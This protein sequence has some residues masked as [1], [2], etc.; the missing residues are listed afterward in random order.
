MTQK[1][2]T[3]AQ[4]TRAQDFLDLLGLARTLWRGKF[5]ITAMVL[6]CALVGVL[7]SFVIATPMYR[8][9]AVVVLNS[10]EE[11]VLDIESVVGGL[12]AD[13]AVMN[14]EV[15]VISSR[16]L[17]AEVVQTLDL[18][19]DPEFN[20][21]LRPQTLRQKSEAWV[22]AMIADVTGQVPSAPTIS[23]ERAQARVLRGTVNALEQAL[24]VR[25]VPQ[26]LVFEIT[27]ETTDPLK[28]ALISDTLAERYIENQLAVKYEATKQASGWLADRVA[29]LQ[30][31]LE[32]AEAKVKR[33]RAETDLVSAEALEAGERQLKDLRDR[34][35]STRATRDEA[36]ARL[37]LMQGA[38]DRRAQA[39]AAGDAQLRQILTRMSQEGMAEAFDLRFEQLIQRVRLE[40]RRFDTQLAALE[41]SMMQ[42]TADVE[43]Q[44][45]ELITLQQLSREAEASRLLYEYFL[46]RL[47]ETSAQQGLQQADSRILTP[48]EEPGGPATPRKALILGL[49]VAFGVLLGSALVLLREITS[50]TYRA[51]DTLESATGYAVMGQVPLIP[52][53]R[54]S[55]TLQYL[56]KKPTSGAAEAIRNLRTTVLM[57]DVRQ[58]PKVIMVSSSLPGEGKTT[59]SL[60][61]AQ[62]LAAMG[63]KVLL[64]EGDIRRRVVMKYL[65]SAARNR[66]GTMI[67][68]LRGDQPLAELVRPSGALGADVLLGGDG[69]MNAA[70]LFSSQGFAQMIETARAQYDHVVI[71]TPPVLVVPDARVISQF[72]DSILL[73][74]KWDGTTR[75]Q[76]ADSLRAFE[77]VRCPVDG[78]VLNQINLRRARRYGAAYGSYN[79]YGRGYY[80]N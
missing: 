6:L 71:D 34:V 41:T 47:K 15:Q 63:R 38:E 33:Y 25:N 43:R 66:T 2:D 80:G 58:P 55:D 52:A 78:L 48:A 12:T 64:I 50:A 29:E 10:R 37:E 67:D 5:L 62:N 51:A 46:S 59:V 45:A 72:A 28:S 54:R 14:T 17:L 22:R 9:T 49:S 70:D 19:E 4:P 16:T 53:R 75:A 18:L 69:D 79:A 26:S 61:L 57:T 42:L 31:E 13:A 76:V 60:A 3:A 44:N 8:A 77:S 39:D 21:R 40:L 1:T 73:V 65:D 7:Y 68:A 30:T 36:E 32:Q 20:A 56:K 74:V 24:T 27:V 23:E 11:Q 35:E